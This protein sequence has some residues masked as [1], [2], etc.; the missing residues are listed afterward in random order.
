MFDSCSTINNAFGKAVPLDQESVVPSYISTLDQAHLP[1]ISIDFSI[2]YCGSS[3]SLE[4]DIGLSVSHESV[5]GSYLSAIF[6]MNHRNH[7]QNI[8][9]H[10][11]PPPHHMH[12]ATLTGAF[13][14]QTNSLRFPADK[15]NIPQ[16]QADHE[17][18]KL[19]F[20]QQ[21]HFHLI[22]SDP[23]WR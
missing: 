1:P 17:E 10:P 12:L 3:P 7:L 19:N 14:S 18:R 5:V 4:K 20:L 15:A 23:T 9:F 16:E 22:H 6:W 2:Y 11:K 13:S 21:R 8:S